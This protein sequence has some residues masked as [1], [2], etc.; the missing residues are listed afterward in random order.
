MGKTMSQAI[1]SA[2][3]EAGQ[4]SNQSLLVALLSI[5]VI[6]ATALVFSYLGIPG[7]VTGSLATASGA[8]VPIVATRWR[9]AKKTPADHVLDVTTGRLHRPRIYVLITAVGLLALAEW[10]STL[11]FS[12]MHVVALVAVEQQTGELV[13][14]PGLLLVMGN[15]AL[16]ALV[17]TMVTA[18][19]VGIYVAHRI[20]Q[21]PLAWALA[22]ILL[23]QTMSFIIYAIWDGG[24]ASFNYTSVLFWPIALALPVWIGVHRGVRTRLRFLASELFKKLSEDDRRALL[25]V[26]AESQVAQRLGS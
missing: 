8:L 14:S 26:M 16:L 13:E 7:E 20:H 23:A 25:D 12:I 1:P 5:A 10:V 22:A 18:L 24:L 17:T 19:P 6:A 15:A 3:N 11:T 9:E 4:S 21:R 2:T